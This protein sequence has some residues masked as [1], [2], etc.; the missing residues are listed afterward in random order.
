MDVGIVHVKIRIGRSRGLFAVKVWRCPNNVACHVCNRHFIR[1]C[2]KACHAC[3]EKR[4]KPD[5]EQA[6][7]V[8][9]VIESGRLGCAQMQ[10][11]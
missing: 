5:H 7:N 10:R 1:E 9:F 6:G 4:P 8:N 11:R 3:N 2:D